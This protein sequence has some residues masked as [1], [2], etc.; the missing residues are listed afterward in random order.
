MQFARPYFSSRSQRSL[1]KITTKLKMKTSRIIISLIKGWQ[2]S[3]RSQGWI[4]VT[5]SRVV[6]YMVSL[7][8]WQKKSRK[9]VAKLLINSWQQWSHHQLYMRLWDRLTSLKNL[10]LRIV[11][12]LSKLLTK[13]RWW[14]L[15]RACN[16]CL[17]KFKFIGLSKNAQVSWDCLR[18]MRIRT[19]YI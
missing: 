18:F 13:L 9:K 17:M 14:S 1:R 3:Q 19:W 15:N 5:K 16:A 10:I 4:Q 11:K 7:T 12:L 8:N 6:Y 2:S